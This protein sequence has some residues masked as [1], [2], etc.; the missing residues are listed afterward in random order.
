MADLLS[1]VSIWKFIFDFKKG[2]ASWK[3]DLPPPEIS[4]FYWN[5]RV[6]Q[7]V[8]QSKTSPKRKE[9]LAHLPTSKKHKTHQPK[10]TLEVYDAEISSLC[11]THFQ[12]MARQLL[13]WSALQWMGPD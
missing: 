2:I 3:R 7:G 12:L 9:Y 10:G 4:G 6:A 13:E 1:L 8:G 11:V 5:R